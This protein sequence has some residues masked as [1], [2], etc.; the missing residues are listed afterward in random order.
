MQLSGRMVE[1]MAMRLP[2]RMAGISS[3][4]TAC[5]PASSTTQT[6]TKSHRAPSSATVAAYVAAVSA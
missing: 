5:T 3:S 6:H 4:H 2:R 1:W